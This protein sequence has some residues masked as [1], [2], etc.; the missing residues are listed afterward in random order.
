MPS[1]ALVRAK[2]VDSLPLR[3]SLHYC[4]HECKAREVPGLSSG[5]VLSGFN[6]QRPC[7][8]AGWR[9]SIDAD[10]VEPR[11]KW[12]G[13]AAK[14]SDSRNPNC[15]PCGTVKAV[16]HGSL[17]GGRLYNVEAGLASR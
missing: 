11:L 1:T 2:D 5:Y 3:R 14:T 13:D 7:A 16:E 17:P 9:H 8:S 10:V 15:P 12:A 6:C 4:S